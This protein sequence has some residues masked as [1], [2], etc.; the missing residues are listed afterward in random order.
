VGSRSGQSAQEAACQRGPLQEGD[1]VARLVPRLRR[2]P[3]PRRSPPIACA[4]VQ[5]TLAGL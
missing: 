4:P 1:L 2:D 3:I 5:A